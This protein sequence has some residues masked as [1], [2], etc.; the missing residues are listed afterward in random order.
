M[1]DVFLGF[2]RELPKITIVSIPL[3]DT[4]LESHFQLMYYRPSSVGKEHVTQRKQS[5]AIVPAV[6]PTCCRGSVVGIRL[7]LRR[8]DNQS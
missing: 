6:C 5:D 2:L 8:S 3:A 4:N 7:V 1:S